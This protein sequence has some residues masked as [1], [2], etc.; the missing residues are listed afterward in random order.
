[1]KIIDWNPDK[2]DCYQG[3]ICL[4]RIPK[5]IKVNKSAEINKRDNRLILAEGEVTG[6]HHS[7]WLRYE[8]TMF[9]DD[10]LAKAMMTMDSNAVASLFSD[11][12]AISKLVQAGELT[13]P[14][15]AIGI[16]S[17]EGGSM[18]LEHNEHDAIRIPPGNYYVGNQREWDSA[19][20]RKVLD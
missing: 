4:F 13:G 16:L 19:Q 3:D 8:P 9:R 20:A 7:I 17:I 18:L 5:N 11:P 2:G 14:D 6:H 1:M 12:D 10:G 15:L